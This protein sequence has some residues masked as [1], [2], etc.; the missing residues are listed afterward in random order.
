M[1]VILKIKCT[2]Y[3]DKSVFLQSF[4]DKYKHVSIKFI[5]LIL[6]IY[7]NC[8]DKLINLFKKIFKL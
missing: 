8:K 4:M 7:S 5:L 6:N 1:L 3:Y 2:R